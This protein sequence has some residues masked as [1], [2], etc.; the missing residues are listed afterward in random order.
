MEI[1]D[2]K[3]FFFLNRSGAFNLILYLL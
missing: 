3:L 2:C 1:I